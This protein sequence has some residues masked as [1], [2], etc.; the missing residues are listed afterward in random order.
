MKSKPK[1]FSIPGKPP[2]NDRLAWGGIE[3]RIFS[4]DIILFN[5]REM[6]LDLGNFI[7][8]DTSRSRSGSLVES[9]R[10][11]NEDPK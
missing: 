7:V 4:V 8:E 11:E 2:K 10:K 6:Y 3:F 5:T 9:I 1:Y